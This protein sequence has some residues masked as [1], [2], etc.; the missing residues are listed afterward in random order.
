MDHND[1][2]G[3]ILFFGTGVVLLFLILVVAFLVNW[4]LDREEGE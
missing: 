1:L 3:L 4:L 2:K